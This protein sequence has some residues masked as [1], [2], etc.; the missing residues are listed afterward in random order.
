M[1]LLNCFK[2]KHRKPRYHYMKLS[3]ISLALLYGSNYRW[4]SAKDEA[5]KVSKYNNYEQL[6]KID[7]KNK[8][9]WQVNG[10]PLE[11]D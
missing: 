4:N 3:Q 10:K 6:F 2:A 5:V 1:N 11:C 9:F 7:D 8:E